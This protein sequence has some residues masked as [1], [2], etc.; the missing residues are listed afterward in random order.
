LGDFLFANII[1]YYIR[2]SISAYI[3]PE[4]FILLRKIIGIKK[5]TCAGLNF[6]LRNN[7]YCDLLL[8]TY[9]LKIKRMKKILGL[10]IG[11]NSIGW[12]LIENDIKEQTGKI[13]GI[14]SRIVP[15]EG[16]EK[17]FEAG[18]AESKAAERRQARGARRLLQRYKL[19]RQRLIKALA[20]LG[21]FPESFPLNF[22]ELEKFNI[23]SFIPYEPSTI[24]EAKNILG[25]V[26][27]KGEKT[28]LNDWIIYYLRTKALTQQIGLQELGRIIYHFNQRRG[29]KSSRKEN[30]VQDDSEEVK[31]PKREK[32]IEIVTIISVTESSEKSKYGK[33]FEVKYK[34][35]EGYPFTG[36]TIRKSKPDW[37]SKQIELEITQII[38][39]DLSSRFELRLPDR[40]DWEKMKIALEKD[41]NESGLH[42]GQYHLTHI[43][44][45][46]NYRIKE[47]IID[48]N[49][50]QQELKA[51]WETQSRFYPSL[52]NTD[53]LP[54][55]I[56]LLYPH[57]ESKQKE[58]N[59]KGL[60]NLIANDIIYYQRDLKSQ[61]HLIADCRYERKNYRDKSG[62]QQAFKVISKSHPSFQ[63]FR[64]WQDIHN[65]KI[66]QLEQKNEKG[67]MVFDIDVSGHFLTDENKEKL[68]KLF[69]SRTSITQAAI[70]KAL[71]TKENPL[72]DKTHRM[73][74]P[75]EKEFKGNETKAL[76]RK[77]FKRHD[78]TEQGESLLNDSK[79]IDLLWHILYSLN[80]E[81][82]I[83]NAVKNNFGFEDDMAKHFAKL[84]EFKSEYA[85]FSQKAI[86]K[87]LPLLRCGN[88][89]KVEA[90]DKIT[91]GRIEKIITGEFDENI[92]EKTRQE[93]AKRNFKAVEDFKGLPLF[94]TSYVV[95]GRHSERENEEKYEQPEDV[96][97]LE[98]G[99][100]RNPIVEQISNETLQVVKDIWKQFGR[101]D[102]IHI[103]LARDLKKNNEERQE[104]TRQN[105][106]NEADRK[107]ITAILKELSNTNPGSIGDIERLR[108]W[109]ETGNEQ[110]YETSIKFSKE[111]TKAEIEKYKLWGEQNHISPYTGKVIPLSLLFTSAYQIE[112]IIPRSRFFDDSFGNKTICEA[113][114]NSF[115]DNSTAMQLINEY[116]GRELEHHGTKFRLLNPDEYIQHI[117]RTFRGKKK[118]AF[119]S[120]TI[121]EG[122]IERQLNDTRYIG[123]KLNE[124]LYPVATDS[125]IFTSGS[126]TSDLKE[127]WGLHRVWKNLLQPR[128]ERLEKI[129]GEKLIS[130]DNETNNI[131]FKKDYKR[132]DHR[133]HALDA[134][135]IAATSRS[136]IQYLNTLNAQNN[137]A[138]EKQKYSYLVK[139][140][141]R[142]FILPWQ[143]FTKDAREALEQIIVSH[144][145]RIRLITK[146]FNVITKYVQDEKGKWLKKA[147]KQ[148]KGQLLSVRKS[149]FK[150]PLGKILIAEYKKDVDIKK[151]I[152]HQLDFTQK[153]NGVWKSQHLRVALS[154]LRKRIDTII[155]NCEFDEK[156]VLKFLTAN[157]LTDKEYNPITKIDLLYFAEY[158][159]KRRTINKDFKESTLESIP[160]SNHLPIAKTIKEHLKEYGADAFTGEGLE[161]LGKKV[162]KPVTKITTYEAI[163]SKMD[164]K[165][166]LVEA[167]K[168]SN[169][170]FVIYE[171]IE[172]CE[173]II[174][175]KS[176]IPILEAIERKANGLPVADEMS[177]Y[178][179]IVLS[180][181]DLVYV[182]DEEDLERIKAKHANPINWEN[183]KRIGNRIY[184]VMSFSGPDCLFL[185]H[186]VS[187]LI[188]PYDSKI[189]KGEF[190]SL[191]KTEKTIDS[192]STIKRL[193]VKIK[194]D[195]L[196]NI[197]PAL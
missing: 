72:I 15:M 184:K 117:D 12:A 195:R 78:Y 18:T 118:R 88:C 50:Y 24:D 124:L 155:K 45:N 143:T 135:I 40:T 52:N 60:Y 112:H 1:F 114:V 51:I 131:H 113:A 65:L 6:S 120:E 164:F 111:P 14:G 26:N 172:T 141:V 53:K 76:F 10:D 197:K 16:R 132:I 19:R 178:R 83:A 29:F 69:D 106:K 177:G 62:K 86:N 38:S 183:K 98:R 7:P 70:L 49:F 179:S 196:G 175:E 87:L 188:M 95:Y 82:Y 77:V 192:T 97:I 168:G 125:V 41:M 130:F 146:G 66:I 167:D 27:K 91:I 144:K 56:A 126:I 190:G 43:I 180:P 71:S 46:R 20:Q 57:N 166:K 25:Y 122:F 147:I 187:S 42:P 81:K 191:N 123:R 153:H 161:V 194:I 92:N 58:L 90:I 21:W 181:N 93:I 47:R 119:K 149:M 44:A 94:L 33:V 64:I 165:G 8:Q 157:P 108:L 169:L 134:L 142:E 152:K 174:N 23:N 136:H 55:I 176:S 11:T 63:E 121:P 85:S 163:G 156:T 34:T 37:E 160:Y 67:K 89:W 104:I 5:P 31:Y 9:N 148:A 171:N 48:R 133:H 145:N 99:E 2:L 22:K 3:L 17:D 101:P 151:A 185:P 109:E 159:A 84:P 182:P 137:S 128:F 170:Y 30:K 75:E 189:K 116:G 110:A 173:R 107:R 74:Y 96:N 68:F 28:L 35:A 138:D 36:T 139:A 150:E 80:D 61:K 79:K 162:G 73:N 129:T 158:S 193:C 59:E 102:E 32:G 103:E 127:K 105:T 140:K 39:K 115:K 54:L 154:E 13:I 186:Y 100:L 4:K